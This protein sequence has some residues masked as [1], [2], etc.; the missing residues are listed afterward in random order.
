MK[1]SPRIEH[2]TRG[3]NTEHLTKRTEKRKKT[4]TSPGKK[5]YLKGGAPKSI[6]EDKC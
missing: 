1:N 4:E 2:K 3:A 5:V 6:S